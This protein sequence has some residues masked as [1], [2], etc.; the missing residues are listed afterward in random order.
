MMYYYVFVDGKFRPAEPEAK[1]QHRGEGPDAGDSQP[2]PVQGVQREARAVDVHNVGLGQENKKD[3]CLGRHI[4]AD[5][6]QHEAEP[7]AKR[8]RRD[9]GPHVGDSQPEPVPGVRC[10]VRAVNVRNVGLGQEN[11]TDR[12]LGGRRKVDRGRHEA[13]GVGREGEGGG[14]VDGRGV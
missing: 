7:Q 11:T 10:K 3:R 13:A 9:Q 6:R 12:R 2:E 5:H 1:R 4:K 14:R 8:Q